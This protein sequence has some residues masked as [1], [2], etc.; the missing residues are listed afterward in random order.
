MQDLIDSL[1]RSVT[2]MT[3]G[4]LAALIIFFVAVSFAATAA[5]NMLKVAG[6]VVAILAALYV[7]DPAIYNSALEILGQFWNATQDVVSQLNISK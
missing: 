4:S 3:G 5:R 6:T 2:D 7:V 1:V